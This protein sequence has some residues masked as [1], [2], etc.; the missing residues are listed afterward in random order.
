MASRRPVES[1]RGRGPT[2]HTRVAPLCAETSVRVGC[3]SA[4]ESLPAAKWAGSCSLDSL[5]STGKVDRLIELS[6][7]DTQTPQAPRG[8]GRHFNWANLPESFQVHS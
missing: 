8:Q 3:R 7:A 5:N 1:K 6:C 2:P 4:A